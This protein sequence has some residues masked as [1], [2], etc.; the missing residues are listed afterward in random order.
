MLAFLELLAFRASNPRRK[1][2]L[3]ERLKPEGAR[4]APPLPCEPQGAL[5]RVSR[6]AARKRGPKG[7]A[8]AFRLPCRSG[9]DSFKASMFSVDAQQTHPYQVTV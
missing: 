3:R 9:N 1:A 6:C 2:Q 4:H 7:H 5:R 8:R